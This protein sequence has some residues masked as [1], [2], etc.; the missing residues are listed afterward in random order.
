MKLSKVLLL[1]LFSHIIIIANGQD[2][3]KIQQPQIVSLNKINI[4]VPSIGLEREQKISKFSTLSIGV[5]YQYTFLREYSPYINYSPSSN[6]Y[7]IQDQGVNVNT[8]LKA[9]PGASINY[10][11]YYNVDKRV[12]QQKSILKNSANYIAVDLGAIFPRMFNENNQYDYQLMIT[13]NWG[14]QRNQNKNGNFEFAIG[15]S[16]VINPYEVLLGV[17]FK[18]GASIIL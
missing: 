15:P 18:V 14:I 9:V 12:S 7:Q 1:L 16:L 2:T 6:G 4:F 11:Y 3:T 5:N 10:R 13:P 17:G 8:K